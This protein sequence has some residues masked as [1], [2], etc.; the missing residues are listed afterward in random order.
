MA[1]RQPFGFEVRTEHAQ[2][3]VEMNELGAQLIDSFLEFAD[4]E[5][6]V[7]PIA[8]RMWKRGELNKRE[9]IYSLPR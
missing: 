4:L 9:E 8:W 1:N 2:H 5:K 3:G 6:D 7:G